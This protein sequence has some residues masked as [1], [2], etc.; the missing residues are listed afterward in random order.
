MAFSQHPDS[1]VFDRFF[2]PARRA[3]AV[4]GTRYPCHRIPDEDCLAAA[5][6]DPKRLDGSGTLRKEAAGHFVLLNLWTHF[7]SHL[8]GADQGGARKREHDMHAIK[9]L[10]VDALRGGQPKGRKVMLAWDRAGIDFAYWHNAKMSSGL[11]FISRE[12]ENMKL[13]RWLR[14]FVY[15]GTSWEAALARLRHVYAVF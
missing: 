9:R 3:F 11:Y 2:Q 7:L 1:S 4:S 13:I 10:E 5:F 15:R 6:H 8:A 12:K 14:N